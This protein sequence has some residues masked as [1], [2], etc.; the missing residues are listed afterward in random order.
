MLVENVRVSKIS[1]GA[2]A[3]SAK[4]ATTCTP[5]VYVSII[6]FNCFVFIHTKY[7]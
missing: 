2:R 5:I 6:T 4:Q 1:P 7:F 3:I